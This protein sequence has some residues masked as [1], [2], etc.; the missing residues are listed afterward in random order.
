MKLHFLVFAHT[1]DIHHRPEKGFASSELDSYTVVLVIITIL[2]FLFLTMPM[3]NNTHSLTTSSVLYI[4]HQ[5]FL[6][7]PHIRT[8][9]F[10]PPIKLIQY[11]Y[12]GFVAN[13][14]RKTPVKLKTHNHLFVDFF[15][16]AVT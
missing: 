13:L 4:F 8:G 5:G 14:I 9:G 2:R 10:S 1:L 6:S 3:S 11:P 12:E 7:S 15:Y 16:F